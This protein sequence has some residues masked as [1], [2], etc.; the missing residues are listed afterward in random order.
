M[1]MTEILAKL[2]LNDEVLL[3]AQFVDFFGFNDTEF[4]ANKYLE[5]LSLSA[6]QPERLQVEFLEYQLLEK[7]D[8]PDIIL[9][10]VR[11]KPTER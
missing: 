5:N 6:S 7:S 3:Q 11:V 1:A 10:D 2:P 9:E 8:T 4:F